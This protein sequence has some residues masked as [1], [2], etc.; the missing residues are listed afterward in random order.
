LE[1]LPSDF[2]AD[3]QTGAV[4]MMHHFGRDFA[5]LHA[6]LPLGLPY[7]GLLGPR[8]RSGELLARLQEFRALDADMLH[9]LHA[10]AGLDIGSEAPEE[11]ALSIAAEAGAV[12]AG[13]R[14]GLLRDRREAIHQ[15]LTEPLE[16]TA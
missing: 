9:C 10:P 2:R 13:R 4:V 12:L 7:I 8:R 3:S 5:V 1:E 14:G 15:C 16:R 6:L 11:I